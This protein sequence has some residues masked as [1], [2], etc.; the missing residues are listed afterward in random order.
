MPARRCAA[1]G[2]KFCGNAGDHLG[3]PLAGELAGMNGGLIVVRGKAGAYAGDR[4]RR[5]LIA[6]L[7]GAGDYAGQPA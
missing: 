6:V 3:G 5:G 1:G 7:K 4:M 2:S